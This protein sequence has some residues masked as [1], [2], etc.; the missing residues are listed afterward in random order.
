MKY[1]YKV[2]TVTF[3][4]KKKKK[5]ERNMYL[6][7]TNSFPFHNK[8]RQSIPVIN[9]PRKGHQKPNVLNKNHAISENKI[10]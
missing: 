6:I 4:P 8:R 1:W 9:R 3:P 10:F 2:N 5:E 7:C